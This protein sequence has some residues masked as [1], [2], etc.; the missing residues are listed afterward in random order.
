MHLVDGGRELIE[1][2]EAKPKISVMTVSQRCYL[3]YKPFGVIS[4]GV[5]NRDNDHNPP[6]TIRTL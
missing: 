5:S 1:P 3:I 4:K 2:P 6:V